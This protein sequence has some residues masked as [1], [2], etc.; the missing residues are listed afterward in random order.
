[1]IGKA[2]LALTLN[3]SGQ[4]QQQYQVFNSLRLI[5]SNSL[6]QYDPPRLGLANFLCLS[7]RKSKYARYKRDVD[8]LWSWPE[9]P[10][11]L[12]LRGHQG[13]SV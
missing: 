12:S 1:M 4:S 3:D 2:F 10:R 5:I 7:F 9:V 13:L 11:L 6:Q 8:L